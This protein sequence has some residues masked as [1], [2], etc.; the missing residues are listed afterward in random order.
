M[1]KTQINWKRGE[2]RATL[3]IDLGFTTKTINEINP[4][5][6][7]FTTKTNNEKTHLAIDLGFTTKTNNKN[8][9]QRPETILNLT[10]RFRE[11]AENEKRNLKNGQGFQYLH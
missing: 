5:D 7:G 1:K 9:L 11:I 4:I 3:P 2:E 10:A 6:L 8:T